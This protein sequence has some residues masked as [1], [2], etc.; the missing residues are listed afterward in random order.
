MGLVTDLATSLRSVVQILKDN[1]D[2][3]DSSLKD[4]ARTAHNVRVITDRAVVVTQDLS[5]P[6]VHRALPEAVREQG[7]YLLNVKVSPSECVYPMVPAGAG[8]A[9]MVLGP[10]QPVAV[11]VK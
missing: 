3:L 2:N 5:R 9:E 6:D 4:I 1:Q 8:I 7:P 10:P 11:P